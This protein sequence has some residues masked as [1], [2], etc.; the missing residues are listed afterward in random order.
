MVVRSVDHSISGPEMG[1]L[2][3]TLEEM[4]SSA[5]MTTSADQETAG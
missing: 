5:L 2:N 1:G 4:E 3:P